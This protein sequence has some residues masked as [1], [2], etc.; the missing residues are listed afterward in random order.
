MKLF[1]AK[2]GDRTLE[3]HMLKP[4]ESFPHFGGSSS[5]LLVEKTPSL[6]TRE[7]SP[8][9]CRDMESDVWN[10][11]AWQQI[12]YFLKNGVVDYHLPIE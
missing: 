10:E 12:R 4:G 2:L 9:G 3:V 6:V 7:V 11:D 1:T 8:Y 5:A